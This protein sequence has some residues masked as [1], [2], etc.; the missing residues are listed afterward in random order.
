MAERAISSRALMESYFCPGGLMASTLPGYESRPGQLDMA[1][2]VSRVIERQD[3]L[4]VEAGT[5]T[6]KTLSYLIPAVLSGKRILISTATR[7]LQEQI[8]GKDVPLLKQ[9]G[10]DVPA[11]YLK[12]RSNYLCLYRFEQFRQ[13]PLFRNAQDGPYFDA[14][15][16]WATATE[17][18]D[19]AELHQLPDS[20]ATW[21]DLSSTP[22]SCLGSQCPDYEACFVTRARRQAARSQVIIVNHHLFF[23]DLAV[24]AGGFG[25]ILPELEVVIFD[26]AHHLEETATHFFGRVI[27]LA[28]IRDLRLD[29]ERAVRGLSSP[30]P[31]L[32]DQLQRYEEEF[33][34]LFQVVGVL[35]PQQQRCQLSA[36]TLE[37]PSLLE[38]KE[39]ALEA[40]RT[41]ERRVMATAALG[42]TALAFARRCRE[43][44]G[45]TSFILDGSDAG[46][47]YFSEH[48]GAR[49]WLSLQACPID[50]GPIF[51]EMLYPQYPIT[52][53]T[54]ATLT[55]EGRFHYYRSRIALGIDQP[56]KELVLPSPFDFHEQALLFVPEGLPEPTHPRFAE[57]I[58]PIIEELLEVTAGRAF[59]LFTSYRNLHL[60][61]EAVKDRL[62]YPILVQGE[63]SRTALLDQ[64]RKIPSVLL[65]TTSFWEGVDVPGENLSL[66]I[67]DKLPFA[68]PADPVVKARIEYIRQQGGE[69]FNQ[70][71]VPQAAIA[72]KQ[73]FGRLIR[74]RRDR[75][76]VA[77]LDRRLLEKSYGQVFLETLPSTG[78]TR[79]LSEVRA[80]W[81]GARLDNRTD[82]H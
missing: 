51:Q 2:A 1:L 30:Q 50:L 56:V 14:I 33:R 35:V 47:V 65:A 43:L 41:L 57:A 75:G 15:L 10:L 73:G 53:F 12:G 76:I 9:L 58:S 81:S 23:G 13:A 40:L 80:W 37:N 16:A 39:E 20:Y 77:I 52:I 74:H 8:Y 6:G 11:T 7:N 5:G 44:G 3:R 17:S 66:V 21:A 72:L 49:H 38:K 55:V 42:E 54:S 61:H 60:V 67:M 36:H 62:P 25:E 82:R 19:R 18:G 29:I 64:F 48:R 71:Q 24:R 46:W 4:V 63:R 59:V 69:P 68:S 34:R 45:D 79:S 22:E 28:R 31:E 26:E 70:Y 27:S 32:S 78:L